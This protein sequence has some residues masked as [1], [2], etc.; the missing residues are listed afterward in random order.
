MAPLAE[1]LLIFSFN[2]GTF[3]VPFKVFAYNLSAVLESTTNIDLKK[4]MTKISE[5][6]NS[7]LADAESASYGSDDLS[8]KPP[9]VIKNDITRKVPYTSKIEQKFN[10]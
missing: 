4:D 8:T 1:H 6:E 7:S 2:S 9:K 5:D 10:R 3:T